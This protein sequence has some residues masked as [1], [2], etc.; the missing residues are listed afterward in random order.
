[1]GMKKDDYMAIIAA[2]VLIFLVGSVVCLGYDFCVHVAEKLGYPIWKISIIYWLT[3]I[4]S[5]IGAI[6]KSK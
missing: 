2:I 1:M 4:I 3:A 6:V 5:V